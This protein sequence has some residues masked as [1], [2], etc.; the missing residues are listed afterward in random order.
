MNKERRKTGRL[1]VGIVFLLSDFRNFMSVWRSKINFG[2]PRQFF[3]WL[4]V[5]QIKSCLS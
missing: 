1:G 3:S 5:F 4:P 2:N